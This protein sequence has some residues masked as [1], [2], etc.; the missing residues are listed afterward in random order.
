MQTML[1]K[2]VYCRDKYTGMRF[3]RL[4]LDFLDHPLG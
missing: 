3:L 2:F 1:L 4:N